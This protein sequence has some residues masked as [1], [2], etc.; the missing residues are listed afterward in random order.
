MLNIFRHLIHNTNSSTGFSMIGL[1]I[2]IILLPFVLEQYVIQLMVYFF[3]YAYLSLCWNIVGGMAGQLSLG[4]VAFLGVSAYT[5]TLLYVDYGLSPWIGMWIGS[6]FSVL[7]ALFIGYLSFR[8]KIRGPFFALITIAFAETIRIIVN[9]VK[10]LGAA[11]GILI[12]LR[13]NE[14]WSY[15][16]TNNTG[17]YFVSLIMMLVV[18]FISF[19]ILK[20]RM[21]YYLLAIK[22][23]EDAA[24]SLGINVAKYKLLAFAISAF[25]TSFGG[26]FYA[27]FLMLIEPGVTFNWGISIE[28]II[29][30]VVGGAG[31][32]FGPVIGSLILTAL[33]EVTHAFLGQYR[34]IHLLAYG[35][36]LVLVVIFIP[37][38]L[39]AGLT[40]L[41]EVI[42]SRVSQKATSYETAK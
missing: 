29:R 1:L 18:M 25:L 36:V 28:M 17:F 7:L 6:L 39:L 22:N 42:L 8:Y 37:S 38:G 35:I 4:H 32:I 2:V 5:S 3:L 26:T 12:P 19:S 34:G 31:T 13:Q 41:K 23:D 14:R 30:S 9:S 15:Q 33:S 10:S 24:N 27:Q 11:E 16:F 20:S 40:K 21:G